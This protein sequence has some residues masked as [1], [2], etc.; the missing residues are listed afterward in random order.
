MLTDW[1][2]PEEHYVH[3]IAN[4][5]ANLSA[6]THKVQCYPDLWMRVERIVRNIYKK[7]EKKKLCLH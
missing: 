2:Y 1:R 4:L 5:K 7:K 3:V 6:V